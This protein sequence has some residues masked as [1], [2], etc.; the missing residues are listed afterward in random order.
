M[1]SNKT[2]WLHTYESIVPRPWRVFFRYWVKDKLQWNSCC[3]IRTNYIQSERGLFSV[4]MR[5]CVHQ[6]ISVH[7]NSVIDLRMNICGLSD[8]FFARESHR[9]LTPLTSHRKTIIITANYATIFGVNILLFYRSIELCN[10][11]FCTAL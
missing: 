1:F 11:M 9:S 10:F 8:D 7:N 6:V 2:W 5:L 4:H 3:L